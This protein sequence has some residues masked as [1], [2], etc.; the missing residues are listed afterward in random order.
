MPLQVNPSKTGFDPAP[1]PGEK[2]RFALPFAEQIK[3]FRGKAGLLLPTEHWDDIT[4]A[5]HD[6][7]FMVAGTTKMDLLA[8]FHGAVE[9]AIAEGKS[10]DW[11]RQNFADIVQKH[12]WDYNGPFDWRSRVIYQTNLQAS[13]AAGR[14]AQLTHPD[15]LKNRPWWKYVHNDSVSHPR[16]PHVAWSGLTLRYDDPWWQAHYPPNGFGCRCRITA[17]A[18]PTAGR[19]TAP[20]DGSYEYVDR[21]GE[22]HAVPA[23]VDY[24][25]GYTPGQA[26]TGKLLMD[27]AAA[28]PASIGARAVQAAYRE[29]D[30]LDE[31][32]THYK[33][34][35]Q[36]IDRAKPKGERFNV[37]ALTPDMVDF[38]AAKGY[39]PDAAAVS[40]G[41]RQL[42]H[43]LRDSKHNPLPLDAWLA[44]PDGLDKPQA[45]L[46]DLQ[47]LQE[48]R[49]PALV[50]VYRT[51]DGGYAKVVV[52]IGYRAKDTV[53]GKKGKI[54]TNA[55]VTGG[56]E[57][58]EALKNAGIFEL[59]Q[60]RLD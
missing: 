59:A 41:D 40:L 32:A 52:E 49:P 43:A 21:W 51:Q 19:D 11:F 56:T 2:S 45:V 58:L 30:L 42:S 53:A 17:V 57:S 55:V 27:K 54:A 25:W 12:G 26:W 9:K 38:L 60:G 24:G 36:G 46:W 50:Y 13:Y 48:G 18:E 47:T 15:L 22:S 34:W 6:R 33:A 7:A 4:G 3:F 16:P 31:V 5:A 37:G 35:A 29:T 44:L 28:V 23:G 39:A 14:Y 10:L 8:D 1:A 20:D